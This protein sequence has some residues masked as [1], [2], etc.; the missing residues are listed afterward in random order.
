MGWRAEGR[1][2]GRGGYLLVL[3]RGVADLLRAIRQPDESFSEVIVRVALD[4]QRL[5]SV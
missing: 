4:R 5:K 3:P 1:I 2:D